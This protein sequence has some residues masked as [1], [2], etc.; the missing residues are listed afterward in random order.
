[1]ILTPEKEADFDHISAERSLA[2]DL[3]RTT[4]LAPNRTSMT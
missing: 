2:Q 4:M 1:M 3:G